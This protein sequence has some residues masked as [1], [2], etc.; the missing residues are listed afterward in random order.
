M[1]AC[2]PKRW[3]VA[4]RKGTRDECAELYIVARRARSLA[5]PLALPVDKPWLDMDT[6]RA[7][8]HN[9]PTGTGPHN[10]MHRQ[11]KNPPPVWCVRRGG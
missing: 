2:A 3:P 5:I 7:N 8:H 9:V 1:S 4:Q 6:T 10:K 11:N